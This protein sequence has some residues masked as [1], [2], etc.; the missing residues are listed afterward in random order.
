VTGRVLWDVSLDPD[1]V[2][3]EFLAGYFGE[4]STRAVCH[5]LS[6]IG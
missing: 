3:T 6:T 1:A 4:A 2:I 5:S